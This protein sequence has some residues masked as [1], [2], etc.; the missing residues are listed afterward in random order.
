MIVII[1]RPTLCCVFKMV[2]RCNYSNSTG[3]RL[4]SR[5]LF[6]RVTGRCRNWII[7]AFNIIS[8]TLEF[9][10]LAVLW[11]KKKWNQNNSG[12]PSWF[13]LYIIALKEKNKNPRQQCRHLLKY[14]VFCTWNCSW[15]RLVL[16]MDQQVNIMQADFKYQEIRWFLYKMNIHSFTPYTFLDYSFLS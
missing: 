12:K 9:W 1:I 16:P 14:S 10:S 6:S 4:C 13:D 5:I 11:L 15:R 2:C 3:N 7:C 8:F